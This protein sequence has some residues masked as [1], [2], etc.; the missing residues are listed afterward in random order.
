LVMYCGIRTGDLFDQRPP[1][2]KKSSVDSGS[3][4]H[5]INS[6]NDKT[7]FAYLNKQR[8]WVKVGRSG[9]SKQEAFPQLA[10]LCD[11]PA[12]ARSGAAGQAESAL[13][14]DTGAHKENKRHCRMNF[15]QC[16]AP[17]RLGSAA[18]RGVAVAA[19]AAQQQQQQQQQ[20]E[21][22][23]LRDVAQGSNAWFAARKGR[24]TASRF[25]AA[26][27]LSRYATP[28]SLWQLM[29]GALEGEPDDSSSDTTRQRTEP[30]ARSVYAL[31]RG[32]GMAESGFWVHR[33]SSQHHARCGRDRFASCVL[34]HARSFDAVS[35]SCG[36]RTTSGLILAPSATRVLVV[37]SRR[38]HHHHRLPPQP[39]PPTHTLRLRVAGLH[40]H[41]DFTPYITCDQDFMLHQ[42][43]CPRP[44]AH[45]FPLLTR[46]P[47]TS[48]RP[49][50]ARTPSPSTASPCRSTPAPPPPTR[51]PRRS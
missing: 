49:A 4:A 7:I 33:D 44:S 1:G 11:K 5:P 29:S 34:P 20:L 16:K 40:Q 10:A 14:R 30:E 6:G 28:R 39:A 35:R 18:G 42:S 27:G 45:S 15:R 9:A 41:Q 37:Q 36:C 32:C 3:K 50:A 25:G 43:R 47:R 19:V 48:P 24:L 23:V 2:S 26:A 13:S 51:R 38:Q 46:R 31:V 12:S 8:L 22:V 17:K 21:V